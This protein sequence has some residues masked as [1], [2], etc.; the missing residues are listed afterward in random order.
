MGFSFTFRIIYGVSL[1]HFLSN[2]LSVMGFN[3]GMVCKITSYM[4]NE[5]MLQKIRTHNNGHM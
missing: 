4:I 3:C 2:K 5:V 1:S